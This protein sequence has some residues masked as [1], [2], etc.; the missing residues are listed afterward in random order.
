MTSWR[1]K[2]LDAAGSTVVL[3]E[4]LQGE[5][6]TVMA[7]C[8]GTTLIPMPPSQDHKRLLDNDEGPNTGG[9]GAY[10]PAPVITSKLAQRIEKEIFIPFMKGIKAENFDFRGIIYF[11][12]MITSIGT[13]GA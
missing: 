8:D 7:F 3:E 10:A 1:K 11:G 5:E 12:L 13:S 4:C 6:V 2:P 9:M